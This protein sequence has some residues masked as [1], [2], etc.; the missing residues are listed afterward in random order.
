MTYLDELLVA[1]YRMPPLPPRAARVVQRLVSGR[2]D[3][4]EPATE[5]D[6]ELLEALGWLG[7]LTGGTERLGP[8]VVAAVTLAGAAERH[9][10]SVRAENLGRSRAV[11]RHSVLTLTA[12]CFAARLCRSPVDARAPL[13]AFV[14]ELGKATLLGCYR[15]PLVGAVELRNQLES[16]RAEKRTFGLDHARIG[17]LIAR[18]WGLDEHVAL[19][20]DHHH[21][22][23]HAPHV[24]ARR[25]ALFVNL[26]DAVARRI[27]AGN[28]SAEPPVPE[29]R[30][31]AIGLRASDLGPLV[32]ST[33]RA[34]PLF[35]ETL[36]RASL[37]SPD[38]P[39]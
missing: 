15:P 9:I 35:L 6:R 16:C 21:R 22:P 31:S 39:G 28:T 34:L 3:S 26:C 18:H 17:G 12:A 5:V 24:T 29:T 36:A 1:V 2:S 37:V 11:W 10:V 13:A 7:E 20:V 8:G 30:L 14:H 38:R 4:E 19:A 23:W 25:T 32:R 33:E 27:A